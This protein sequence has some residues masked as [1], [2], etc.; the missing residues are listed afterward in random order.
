ML[1]P[2]PILYL[3]PLG[4]FVL[5]SLVGLSLLWLTLRHYQQR[6]S[7]ARVLIIWWWRWGIVSTWLL[8]IFELG[9][10]LAL[11]FGFYTQIAALLLILASLKM[12]IL[13]KHFIHPALPSRLAYLLYL[14]AGLCLLVT[15]AGA[16]AFDLPL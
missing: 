16:F 12:I 14:A 5:R 4:Y 9:V 15:G 3:A 1:N 10:G 2:F 13:H 6:Q 8:I 11:I 7:L